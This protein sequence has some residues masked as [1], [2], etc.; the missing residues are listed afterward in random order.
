MLVLASPMKTRLYGGNL[1]NIET[2]SIYQFSFF[3]FPTNAV[4]QFL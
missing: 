1:I 3:H 4:P 2:L